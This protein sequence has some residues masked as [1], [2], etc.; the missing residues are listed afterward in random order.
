[1][2]QSTISVLPAGTDQ[3][4]VFPT[5]ITQYCGPQAVVL[6]V[7]AGRG[8][9]GYPKLVRDRVGRLVAVDPDPRIWENPYCHECFQISLEEY[10]RKHSV[11]F[12]CIYAFYVVEHLQNP[13]ELLRA[14]WKLLRIGGNFFAATPNLCHYF[15]SLA[16][17]TQRL[18]IQDWLLRRLRG[19]EVWQSYHFRTQ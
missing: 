13:P 12:D 11:G 9:G 7:G 5:W 10:A 16:L 17:I 8:D 14:V 2:I 19:T 3:W 4:Q 1:M 6:E 15:G 18:G